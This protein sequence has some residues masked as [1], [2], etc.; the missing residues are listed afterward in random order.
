MRKG[1]AGVKAHGKLF[2]IV[3][4]FLPFPVVSF[5][6]TGDVFINFNYS[7]DVSYGPVASCFFLSID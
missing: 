3:D 2:W 1:V 5:A 6:H 4:T 7:S